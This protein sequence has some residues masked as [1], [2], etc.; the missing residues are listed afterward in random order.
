MNRKAAKKPRKNYPINM[1]QI[2]GVSP[3]I[4]L[5]PAIMQEPAQNISPSC[6][7]SYFDNFVHR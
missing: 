6:I 4:W 1:I 3:K 5:G 2:R 7:T